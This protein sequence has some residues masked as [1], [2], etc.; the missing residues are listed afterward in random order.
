M[1]K[2]VKIL[3]WILVILAALA[4]I[5]YFLVIPWAKKAWDN[6]TFSVPRVEAWDLKGLNLNDIADIAFTGKE[7]PVEIRL[8]M[9]VMNKNNFSIPF[10][11][12]KAQLFYNGI[13]IA[14]T[15]DNASHTVPANGTLPLSNL[16]NVNLNTAGG[17]LLVDKLVLGKVPV[18]D[19]IISANV[20]GVPIKN[21]KNNF[22][23]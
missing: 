2:G 5:A 8:G 15:T 23:W 17:Q 19:Y 10:S 14:E 20:F 4:V 1:S 18:I 16:V 11:N 7:K 6:I 21:I 12:I 9:D 3:L 13:Q 22:T